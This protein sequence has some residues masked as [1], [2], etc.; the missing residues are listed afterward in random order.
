MESSKGFFSWLICFNVLDR[1]PKVEWMKKLN[2]FLQSS[3]TGWWQLKDFLGI[4]SPKIGEHE[5]IL[6]I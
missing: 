6:I 4:F 3:K 2:K 5:P 1:P